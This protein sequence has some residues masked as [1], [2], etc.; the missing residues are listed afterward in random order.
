MGEPLSLATTLA[1]SVFSAWKAS[2]PK[3]GSLL[4]NVVLVNL[5]GHIVAKAES[6]G[7]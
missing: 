4:I 7:A 6:R 2:N 5:L 3:A 1:K